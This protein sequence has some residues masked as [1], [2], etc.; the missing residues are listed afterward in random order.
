MT[1]KKQKTKNMI[2]YTESY[3]QKKKEKKK[4]TAEK[5]KYLTCPGLKKY[6]R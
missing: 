6:I 5:V 2:S 4:E 3:C 1:A